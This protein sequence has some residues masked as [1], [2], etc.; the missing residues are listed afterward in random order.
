MRTL[1]ILEVLG[2]SDQ[3]LTAT[4]INASLGL[5]KQTI[6]RLCATLEENGFIARQGHSKRYRVARRLRELGAGLLHNSRDHIARRQIL[7][8][9][10]RQVGETVNYVI[11][12]DS[13]MRYLDRVETDW[14]FRIQLPVGSN[15]PFHCTASGKCFLASLKPAARRAFVEALVL[16]KM[17]AATHVT[18]N[19]LMTELDEISQQGY[20]LD[21]EEFIDGMVA[22]AV[23]VTD[24]FDRFVAS[25]AFHGPTQRISLKEAVARKAILQKAAIKLRE[26]LFS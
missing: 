2:N 17:T 14:A 18:P 8:E 23:P 12:E 13:G 24:E 25:L 9:V 5:P 26:A 7:M 1:M 6:H 19:R 4:E 16:Q 11:P 15:V 20:S 21:N 22:I 3:A 10:A